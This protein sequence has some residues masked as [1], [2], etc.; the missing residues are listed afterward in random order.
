MYFWPN[1]ACH[2]PP[3]LLTTAIYFYRQAGVDQQSPPISARF[4]SQPCCAQAPNKESYKY[5]PLALLLKVKK[6]K[7]EAQT[8]G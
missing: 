1:S 6:H 3:V 8:G 7:G 2:C 4:R 5:W